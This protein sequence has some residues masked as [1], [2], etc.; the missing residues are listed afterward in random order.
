[1]YKFEKPC[2]HRIALPTELR[3]L[4]CARLDSNQRPIPREGLCVRFSGQGTPQVGA[5]GVEPTSP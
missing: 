5:V 3:A 2:Q 4:E 1:M